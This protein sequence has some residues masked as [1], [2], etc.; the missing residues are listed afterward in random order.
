MRWCP[1]VL[2]ML[3]NKYFACQ[4]LLKSG[5]YRHWERLQT[6]LAKI[7]QQ[8]DQIHLHTFIQLTAHLPLLSLLSITQAQF[9]PAR[10]CW[11]ACL[12]WSTCP[13]WWG[14]HAF[15]K[16]AGLEQC[17]LGFEIVDFSGVA[18][19]EGF[20]PLP[21]ILFLMFKAVPSNGQLL[22][23]FLQ[24]VRDVGHLVFF[25]QADF[26]FVQLLCEREGWLCN[27]ARMLSLTWVNAS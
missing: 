11:R 10:S 5:I 19:N 26:Q 18:M 6:Y 24:G 22:L 4:P 23:T 20:L 1:E 15:A 27:S 7:F 13:H 3:I 2:S 8:A 25:L 21:E 16:V 9:S 12:L 14:C 17:H